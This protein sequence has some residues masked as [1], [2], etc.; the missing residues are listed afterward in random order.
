[1]LVQIYIVD[2]NINC[3][4]LLQKNKTKRIVEENHIH[5]N[6]NMLLCIID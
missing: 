1:M 5:I 2:Q 6:L 3:S 4:G